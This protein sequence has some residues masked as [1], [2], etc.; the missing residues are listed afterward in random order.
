[1]S[2]VCWACNAS[3]YAVVF[4]STCHKIQ[5]PSD[6]DAFQ[7][8]DL[9]PT[10]AVDITLLQNHYFKAQHLIHPDRYSQASAREK[11]FAQQQSE[12]INTAYQQL[13]DPVKRAEILLKHAGLALQAQTPDILAAMME[14]QEKIAEAQTS[15]DLE[16]LV[17]DLTLAY[18]EI[19]QKLAGAFKGDINAA[20]ALAGR[21]LYLTKIQHQLTQ[22]MH[23]DQ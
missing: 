23:S 3:I 12:A 22:K 1:M 14:W 16:K 13:K 11:S 18:Q 4:C 20:P 5:P 7:R 2:D 15:V 19:Y 10:F 8:L 17:E 21:L 9:E 6:V